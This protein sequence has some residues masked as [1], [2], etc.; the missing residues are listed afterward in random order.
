MRIAILTSGSHGDVQPYVALARGLHEAG[1]SVCLATHEIYEPFIRTFG[2]DFLPV[3]GNPRA[4]LEGEDGRTIFDNWNLLKAV[5]NLQDAFVSMMENAYHDLWRACEG[6]QVVLHSPLTLGAYHICQHLGIPSCGL[7]VQP[8]TRT[9]AFVNPNVAALPLHLGGG[10]NLFTHLFLEQ[11]YWQALFGP[12]INRWR[13]QRLKLPRIGF[14]GGFTRMY[15]ERHPAI[16]GFSP[17]VLPKP[18]DWGKW[19]H[20]TGYWFL[21]RPAGWEPPA[22]LLHFLESGPPPVY[23]GFGS[24]LIPKAERTT[25]VILQALE[26]SN[27]RAILHSGWAGLGKKDLPDRV[28]RVDY[29]PHEW[30]FPRVAAVV[31][32]GGAGTT[33]AAFRAG[34]PAIAIPVIFD[35]YFWARR[36]TELRAGPAF[37]PNGKLTA[38]RLAAAITAAVSDQ[39]VR[40]RAAAI[41]QA[42]RAE[43][44]IKTAVEVINRL[45]AG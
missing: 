23:V 5:K 21:D 13:T 8:W 43:D 30:L 16:Y 1:H 42:I 24:M 29:V 38:Q 2:V 18:A 11:L 41:G 45:F 37:I 31:H 20:V 7:Y 3:A 36:I 12:V 33:A 19:V 9:R 40:A 15:R 35:Q 6:A 28:L 14:P 17:Q 32:H 39:E 44:G 27:Q 4:V 10:Y 26:L 22:E 34:V 25:E